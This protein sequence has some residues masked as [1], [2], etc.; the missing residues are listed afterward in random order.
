[1]MNQLK[2]VTII[3]VLM[4]TSFTAGLNLQP[5]LARTEGTSF[6][7]F[8]KAYDILNSEYLGD[9]KNEKLVQGAIRGMIDSVGDPYTRYMDPDSYKEMKEDRTGSFSG[10]GIQIGVR[11]SKIGDKEI[12]TVTVISP[13]E[14]TPAWKAGLKAGDIIVQVD[15]KPTL[16][17]SVEDAVKLIKGPRG[18]TVKMKIFREIDKK[19]LD[20][21]IIRDDIVVKAVKQKM[22]DNKIGFVR[23]TSFMS[24]TA[25]KELRKS[26]KSLKDQGMKALILDLR[27]N[28]GGLLPN[29]VDIGSMFVQ[30]GP[31][32]QVVDKKGKKEVLDADGS[33]EIPLTMPMV[34]LIDE[35]SAS[36]SEIVAGAL[37]DNKRATL[38]GSTT[39]GKGLV[40][41]VHELDDGSGMAITTNKYLTSNGTDIN[42]KGINPDISIK[43][44]PDKIYL[45]DSETVSMKDDLQLN[46]AIEVLTKDLKVTSK[47]K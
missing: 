41:T 22:L 7:V 26:I 16:N 47:V 1:M 27:Y 10:I 35:G 5:L 40:Q 37:K 11:K 2:N 3:T 32:V 18:T 15:D 9:I 28:P 4:L 36:A 45:I 8:L 31:I 46:K 30:K 38:I 19:T 44:S 14:D 6:G 23:L 39:Y 25:P 20:F 43:I 24:N 33:L 12:N 42:K 17:I 29:A 21:S 13:M 34:L